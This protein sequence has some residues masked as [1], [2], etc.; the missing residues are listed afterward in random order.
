MT[1]D[2]D[3][4]DGGGDGGGGG[5]E[6]LAPEEQLREVLQQLRLQHRYCTLHGCRYES[7]DDFARLAPPLD[8]EIAQLLQDD[9]V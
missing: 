4:G 7:D 5:F 6:A 8:D 2:G 3:G 9:Q 1:T